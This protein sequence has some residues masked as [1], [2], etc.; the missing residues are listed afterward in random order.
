MHADYHNAKQSKLRTLFGARWLSQRKTVQVAHCLVHADYYKAKQS[1]S[2]TLFG[3]RWLS[4][5]KTVVPDK[6]LGLSW[7][8]LTINYY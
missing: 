5:R 2:R 8:L 6:H 4:Q 1:K 7:I 3:A